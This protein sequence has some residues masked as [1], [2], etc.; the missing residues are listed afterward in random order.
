M[1]KKGLPLLGDILS[2]KTFFEAVAIFEEI[3]VAMEAAGGAELTFES[4]A[5]LGPALG[6]SE[7]ALEVVAVL[8]GTIAQMAV[9]VYLFSAT[10]CL[11]TAIGDSLRRADL[12]Q[13]PEGFI[14][15]QLV[16]QADT[17]AGADQAVG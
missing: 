13:L 16:A 17:A 1:R 8:A 4:L 10:N 11:G 12:D 14:Q 3:H 9:A 2:K 15:A 7:S 5:E 6:L